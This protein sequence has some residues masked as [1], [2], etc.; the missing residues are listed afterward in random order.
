MPAAQAIIGNMYKSGACPTQVLAD[1]TLQ[2][3]PCP[4]AFGAVLGTQASIMNA[5]KCNDI[6]TS[7][8]WFA[9]SCRLLLA[10]YRLV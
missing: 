9:R 5:S 3:L 10:S 6:N 2:H 4:D 8:R 7:I 1:G